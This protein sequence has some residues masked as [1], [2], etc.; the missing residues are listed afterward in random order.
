MG[1]EIKIYYYS[2]LLFINDMVSS[3][4]LLEHQNAMQVSL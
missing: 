2:L 4:Y 3:L 1:D